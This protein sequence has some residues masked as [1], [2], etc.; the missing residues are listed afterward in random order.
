MVTLRDVAERAEVSISTVSRILANSTKETYPTSTHVKVLRASLE[1]GYH[2]NFAARALAS[3]RSHI[4]AVVFPHIYDTPFTALSSLQILASVDG[5]CSE[6]SY[7]VMLSSPRLVDGNVDP[8]F[9]SLLA[10]GY[11][12]GI[13]IDGHYCID[14]FMDVLKQYAKPTVMLGYQ[15][16]PY[17]LRS[18]NFLGGRL[19]MQHLIELGHREIGIVGISQ[20][21]SLAGDQRLEGLRSAAVEQGIDFDTLPCVNG[22]FSSASGAAAAHE[23]LSQQPRLTA[24][25]ALNDRM[26]MGAIRQI[27][28]MGY[29]VPDQISVVGYDD[30]PQSGEFSPALTTVNQQLHTW[31]S[32]AMN[33]LFD[34]LNGQEPESVILPPRLVIRQS[35]APPSVGR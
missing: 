34:L 29:A 9:I 31:G 8:R 14:P 20:G 25:I 3:G 15:S 32:I 35:T 24:I 33:M 21:V 2:P 1:L 26:A 27:Q 4:V 11:P 13:I 30:L 28:A 22:V 18:D 23:L 6:N 10:G 5:F 19:L 12:D 16:H 7:H 17:F